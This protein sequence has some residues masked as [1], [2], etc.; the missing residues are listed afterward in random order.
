VIKQDFDSTKL[1]DGEP[2]SLYRLFYQITRMVG[3]QGALA[4]DDRLEA[5]ARAVAYDV[6]QMADDAHMVVTNHQ[7][8]KFEKELEKVIKDASSQHGTAPPRRFA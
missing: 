8:W 7:T 2:G 1:I 6:E 3:P 5:L 4:K